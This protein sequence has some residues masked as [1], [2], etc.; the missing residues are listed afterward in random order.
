MISWKWKQNWSGYGE[1]KP[2]TLVEQCGQNKNKVLPKDSC[3]DNYTITE[4]G[5]TMISGPTPAFY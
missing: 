1:Q 3:D 2:H 4:G 5:G